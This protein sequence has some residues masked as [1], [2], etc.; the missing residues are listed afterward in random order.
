MGLS[1]ADVQ[2]DDGPHWAEGHAVTR[3]GSTVSGPSHPIWG[4]SL[5]H[6]MAMS[7]LDSL[8][9]ILVIF[10]GKLCRYFE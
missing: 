4:F 8:Y 6:P 2:C 7:A 5:N 9:D 1:L 10:L 3:V